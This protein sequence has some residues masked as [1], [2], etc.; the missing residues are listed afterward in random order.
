[1]TAPLFPYQLEGAQFLAVRER[2]C[3]FDEMGLG[4]TA[5]AITAADMVR[6][7]RV[8]IICPAAVRAVWVGEIAKW[9][10]TPRRV[11]K[12]RD[13]QDLNLWVRGRADVLVCSY[14]Q[15]ANW[16]Q[17]LG[18][19]LIDLIIFD[20]AHYLKNPDS[21]RTRALLSHDCDGKYGLA[22]WGVQVFF[23]TGTPNPNDAADLW[24]L[25]R[26][27]K[28]TTLTSGRFQDRYYRK[29][30]GAY[31][32]SHDP[33]ADM[34][35]ELRQA[36][37]SVALKRTPG[38][39]GLQ[40]PPLWLTTQS[41]DG[42]TEEIKALLRGHP[43]LEDVIL[44][45]IEEGGLSFLDAQHIATLRR[46]VGEAKAPAY[47]ELVRE[48][49]ASGLDKIVIFGVHK[50]ALEI[51]RDGLAAFG[52]VRIDGDVPETQR[53][54]AMNS[55]QTD[56]RCRVMV[57]NIKSGGTGLTMTAAARLDM[58]EAEW[59]PASNAQA[60][61]R[62]HRIGQVQAVQARFISL[63]NS[64]DEVV[65]ETVARKTAAIAKVGA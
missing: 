57:A 64:I 62:V 53:V 36:V 24:S 54:A 27:C 38:D 33:R 9:S 43:G 12:A 46:L 8:L 11:L 26:F 7:K 28:G 23:L 45:A 20:E 39:V 5:Q 6:A 30:Q 31:S 59:A 18:G 42:D 49:L 14:E 19:D 22:R 41:V 35:T 48:E 13:L 51:V 65:S 1:M 4:K 15:A 61:K 3:L 58:F 10:R 52:V 44:Q 29:R 47:V 63:L 40:L 37:R 17:R 16:S 56:P 2:A 60:I 55:F 25:L 50:R 34:L 21:K 32:A